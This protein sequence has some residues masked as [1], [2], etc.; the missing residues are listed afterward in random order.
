MYR[1]NADN[2]LL[3]QATS[4]VVSPLDGTKNEATRPPPSP[5]AEKRNSTPSVELRSS[6]VL[7]EGPPRSSCANP[8]HAFI[9]SSIPSPAPNLSSFAESGSSHGREGASSGGLSTSTPRDPAAPSSHRVGTASQR[10]SSSP[11][12][13]HP[14]NSSS[15]ALPL[16]CSRMSLDSDGR[17]TPVINDTSTPPFSHEKKS[18]LGSPQLKPDEAYLEGQQ[19]PSLVTQLYQKVLKMKPEEPF[20]FIIDQ[21]RQ[22]GEPPSSSPGEEVV[23]TPTSLPRPLTPRPQS[24]RSEADT[25]V[26]PHGEPRL[27]SGHSDSHLNVSLS[28]VDEGSSKTVPFQSGVS[29][30]SEASPSTSTA[31]PTQWSSCYSECIGAGSTLLFG[32]AP[33]ASPDQGSAITAP[34]S[35]E[36]EGERSQ[37][38]IFSDDPI[39]A[40]R[41]STQRALSPSSPPPP[42]WPRLTQ[43]D[44]FESNSGTSS[45]PT[46]ASPFML[47]S[48][49]IGA[50]HDFPQSYLN[51]SGG[52]SS[53]GGY[54]RM[55]RPALPTATSFTLARTAGSGTPS[56]NSS[57]STMDLSMV[58]CGSVD[59]LELIGEMREAEQHALGHHH[60]LITL[61]ELCSILDHVNA[62][63]PDATLL[64]ELFD[65]I[66]MPPPGEPLVF[67]ANAA[68]ADMR[69]IS[70]PLSPPDH[71]LEMGLRYSRLH[72]HGSSLEA[73]VDSAHASCAAESATAPSGGGGLVGSSGERP[74][75][76]NHSSSTVATGLSTNNRLLSAN[77][78]PILSSSVSEHNTPSLGRCFARTPSSKESAPQKDRSRARLSPEMIIMAL[79]SEIEEEE[80]GAGEEDRLAC[81]EQ[82]QRADRSSLASSDAVAVVD[83]EGRDHVAN[84]KPK[85]LVEFDTFLCR[86]SFMIQRRYSQGVMRSVFVEMVEDIDRGRT[87][88]TVRGKTWADACFTTL[89]L[90]EAPTSPAVEEAEPRVEG[91]EAGGAERNGEKL[92]GKPFVTVSPIVNRSVSLLAIDSAVASPTRMVPDDSLPPLASSPSGTVQQS[93]SPS[94]PQGTSFLHFSRSLPLY[95]CIVDGVYRRLGIRVVCGAQI[96]QALAL[97]HLPEDNLYW[98]CHINDFV[99]LVQAITAVISSS[100]STS[101]S[102]P[103]SRETPGLCS[104]VPGLKPSNPSFSTP[105]AP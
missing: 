46:A 42:L 51:G 103:T 2:Q 44:S 90:P 101:V 74:S 98:E 67:H 17:A 75:C 104:S 85:E 31:H 53:G 94:G 57:H 88:T 47:L 13:L 20:K 100:S 1:T 28:N 36:G 92:N 37:S 54:I 99:S 89:L 64:S 23:A 59:V 33:E 81:V 84:E 105:T 66:A 12:L 48:E 68:R 7:E 8:S 15:G 80:Q 83:F 29:L 41:P 52:S 45:P 38:S 35:E 73:L 26:A 62:P 5:S 40:V 55:P 95:C 22:D 71:P 30:S 77:A 9:R 4:M 25:P 69:L 18:E 97:V 96:Q 49:L 63:L 76:G 58:S 19:V 14:Q 78:A 39:T 79:Q 87:R 3:H 50:G 60:P 24:E 102:A 27:S 43:V 91:S 70:P 72:K 11:A 61:E 10:R 34:P 65:E 32:E 56:L 16:R 6:T 86:L 93:F 21:L 82:Q